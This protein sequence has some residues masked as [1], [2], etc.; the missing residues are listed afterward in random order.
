MG[1]NPELEMSPE[2]HER[3]AVAESR[4]S[5]TQADVAKILDLVE[6]MPRRMSRRMRRLLADC[7]AQQTQVY[8]PK[9]KVPE[10][11]RDWTQILRNVVIGATVIGSLIGGAYQAIRADDKPQ[12]QTTQGGSK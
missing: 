10:P 2:V 9:P 1:A 11:D 3:I 6:K 12:I 4:I 5:T 7:R 8:G